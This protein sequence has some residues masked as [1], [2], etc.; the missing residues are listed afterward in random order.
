MLSKQRQD[1]LNFHHTITMLVHL[2][3]FSMNDT[4]QLSLNKKFHK[5]SKP[6]T[7]VLNFYKLSIYLQNLGPGKREQT[8][9]PHVS[10]PISPFSPGRRKSLLLAL[11]V[12][13]TTLFGILIATV[14]SEIAS[15]IITVLS[16]LKPPFQ[17]ILV[18][19]QH[20]LTNP[21]MT[22]TDSTILL[23]SYTTAN[24]IL[25]LFL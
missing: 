21:N 22:V 4:Q 8:L 15:S 14:A 12:V 25:P 19:S 17:S 7:Q 6:G 2:K 9:A 20:S 1:T 13:T 5:I 23:T 24:H 18:F 11:A 3:P 16:L 10:T